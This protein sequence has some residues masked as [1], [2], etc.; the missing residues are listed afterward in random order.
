MGKGEEKNDVV[1][2]S[3][4]ANSSDE[5][6]SSNRRSSD[7]E[8][9]NMSLDLLKWNMLLKQIED[10]FLLSSVLG[11]RPVL[12]VPSLPV[13]KTHISSLSVIN[14]LDKGKGTWN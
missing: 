9:E 14:L 3:S 13:L 7:A 1:E 8:W 10:L 5:V 12:D 11:Q 4:D 2:A 6:S